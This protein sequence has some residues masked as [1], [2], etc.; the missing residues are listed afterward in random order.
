MKKI[1][2]KYIILISI[3][4]IF[5][6]FGYKLCI[7]DRELTI[8]IITFIVLIIITLI[9]IILMLFINQKE[10]IKPEKA[11]LII[12]IT[13][14]LIMCFVMPISKGHDEPIHGYRIY[15]YLSGKLV[16]NSETVDLSRG[17]IAVLENK[18]QYIN[19][20]D[21]MNEYDSDREIVTEKSRMSTY[22]PISYMPHIVGIFI[23]KTI[24][25]NT[26]VQVYVGRIFNMITCITLLYFA[27]K[28]IPYG[29]NMIFILSLIPIA[30]EGYSTLSVDGILISTSMLFIS[31]ILH[32]KNDNIDVG[33]KQI[34]VLSILSI[35]IAISKT[36]Y[37]P[38]VILILL[39]PKQK[40]KNTNKYLIFASIFAVATIIDY[41]WYKNG[42]T[43]FVLREEQNIWINTILSN[44][45]EYI[46][47]MFYTIVVKFWTYLEEIFGGKLEYN[48][49]VSVYVFP[50]IL[51]I[52]SIL[53]TIKGK[54]NK[55]KF[56]KSD[57]ILMTITIIGIVIMVF[58][59]MF[60]S[61]KRFDLPY[62]KGVQGR[63][64]LPILPLIFLLFL[65]GNSDDID[66]TKKIVTI[67]SIMQ[68]FVAMNI[69]IFH[70]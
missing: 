50:F 39:I 18:A 21:N 9:S 22:S 34:L 51:L 66:T 62:I 64:L 23:T 67:I 56:S 2:N 38:L 35:I 12:G 29:K 30:V 14:S 43:N 24:T 70:I 26:L 16:N 19:I 7:T 47:K 61:E 17:I 58:T 37:L 8:K 25:S 54:E 41:L 3:I 1:E 13:F 40:F 60:A 15:E 10:N 20:F 6:F 46:G 45:I 55:I 33:Y 68:I 48:E 4:L 44:P 65:K 28:I 63:Y 69:F 49:N 32:I 59:A 57:K 42:S 27:I 11:F 52:A 53:I 31:Y 5:L 36:I